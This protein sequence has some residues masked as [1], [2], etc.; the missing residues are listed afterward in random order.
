MEPF[1]STKKA[2]R[3][4]GLGLSICKSIVEEHGGKI[5]FTSQEG[6]GTEFTITLP[7]LPRRAASV[8]SVSSGAN[9]P[10]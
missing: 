2:E 1:F 9:A 3:G 10:D 6:K 7:E 4:T 5:T 8:D